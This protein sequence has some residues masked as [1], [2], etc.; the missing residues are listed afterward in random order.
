[1]K[2]L[3]VE[4]KNLLIGDEAADLL[5][6]YAAIVA[7]QGRGDRVDLH[8]ISGDGDEVTTTIV[9]SAGTTFLT[10]T[11]HN[12]LPEPDNTDAIAYMREQIQRATTPPNAVADDMEGME[13]ME[14]Q[15]DDL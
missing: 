1:M 12:S 14:E 15:F 7:D 5:T 6:Q 9:L 4:S 3:T 8:A 10:E 11:A 13:G 2:H